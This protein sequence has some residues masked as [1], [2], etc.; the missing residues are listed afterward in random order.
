MNRPAILFVMTMSLA[1]CGSP[2]S[3]D[4][5][6]KEKLEASKSAP[7]LPD[8]AL[9]DNPEPP[10]A[11]EPPKAEEDPLDS[12]MNALEEDQMEG[13]GGDLSPIPASLRGRWGMSVDDCADP[14]RA[15]SMALE[16]GARS[17]DLPDAQGQLYRTLGEFEDRYVGIFDYN[18]DRGRY[19]AT[20]ELSLSGGNV[21]V[22]QVDGGILRYRRCT[23]TAG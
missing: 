23:R 20:E 7:E 14:R 13:D 19:S 18:G 9:S 2:S 6:T 11:P 10:P 1:A 4:I 17:L 16:V 5:L 12:D 15:G 21:L 22:R 3:E 8:V